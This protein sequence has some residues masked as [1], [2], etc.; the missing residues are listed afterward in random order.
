MSLSALNPPAIALDF[1]EAGKRFAGQL[2]P[3]LRGRRTHACVCCDFPIAVYG[4][5][6][7]C[8]HAFCLTCAAGMAQCI[9]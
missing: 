7:P 2:D 9:M 6:A 1:Q 3:R 8:L 4:R 5:C